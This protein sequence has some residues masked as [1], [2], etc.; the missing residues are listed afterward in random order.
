[1]HQPNREDRRKLERA[2]A[3]AERAMLR[4]VSQH[5]IQARFGVSVQ[6]AY[7]VRD[8]DGRIVQQ[9]GEIPP[10]KVILL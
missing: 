7:Q 4:G 8:V 5:E 3:R 6:N 10:E 9:Y 2:L 1:M